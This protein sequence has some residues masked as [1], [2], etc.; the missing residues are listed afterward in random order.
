[1][2][3]SNFKY[4]ILQGGLVVLIVLVLVFLVATPG[5]RAGLLN[6]QPEPAIQNFNKEMTYD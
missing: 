5:A 3:T 1:M 4:R 2:K 6:I